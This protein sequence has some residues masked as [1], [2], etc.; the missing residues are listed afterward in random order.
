[1]PIK[2]KLNIKSKLELAIAE[3]KLTKKKSTRII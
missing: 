3:E 1:M 2:N